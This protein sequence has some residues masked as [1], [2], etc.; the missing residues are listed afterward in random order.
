MSIRTLLRESHIH[1]SATDLTVPKPAT[2][3]TVAAVRPLSDS[4]AAN[5][6][7][8]IEP[9]GTVDPLWMIAVAMGVTFGLLLLLMVAG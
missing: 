5:E 2:E 3:V 6:D 7:L 1:P 9:A 8:A 4:S